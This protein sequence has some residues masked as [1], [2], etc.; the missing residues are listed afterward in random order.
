M[1][2][3]GSLACSLGD[4]HY[5]ALQLL[6]ELPHQLL[7]VQLRAGDGL[8]QLEFGV[9]ITGVQGEEFA[10]QLLD[11]WLQKLQLVCS[12][13]QRLR[14]QLEP[15]LLLLAGLFQNSAFVSSCP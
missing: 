9:L 3:A 15:D 13:L 12:C 8:N 14:K 4:T 6:G 7:V 5:L 10:L 2:Q 11:S 1:K